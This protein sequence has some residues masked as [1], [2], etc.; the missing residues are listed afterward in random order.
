M[1]RRSTHCLAALLLL[2]LLTLR[3]SAQ[4]T[5][6]TIVSNGPSANRY[7]VAV[8]SE[9]YTSAQL[10]QFRIDA[11]N[12]INTLFTFDPYQEY[13]HYFNA[14]AIAV[15]SAQ[16]GSDHP[17]YPTSRTTYFNS[18]YDAYSDYLI[19]IPAG[20]QGQGKVD[21]LL[22]AFVPDCDLAILLVNDPV[23]GGSDGAA[24][25]AISSVS[26]ISGILVHETGHVVAGLG[27]EYTLANPGYPDTEEPNT[28]R[29]TNRA[30]IKWKAWISQDTPVP[31]PPVSQYDSVVGL[32]EGAH[33]HSNGWYRPKLN[34]I[35]QSPWTPEFCEVCREA[36]VLAFYR[37]VRPID[38]FS[39]GATL[40]S[41]TNP[42]PVTFSLNLL[43][44]ASHS[45]S[46]QWSTNGTALRDA[47]N[48]TFTCWP[49]NLSTGSNWVSAVTRDNTEMVRNDPTNLLAQTVTWRLNV[50]VPQLHLDSPLW[51]AGGKFAFRISG[52]APQGF[53][54]QA[55]TNL[56]T[57]TT[58]STNTLANGQFWFTNSA[59]GPSSKNFF[60]ARTPP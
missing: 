46:I 14:Y 45:L 21:A 37:E 38:L 7:N 56:L 1:D 52:N 26:G 49:T 20:S 53:A 48:Q 60:R 2:S 40:L 13:R 36:T 18:S 22:Q 4:G 28:T 44:P 32:F 50:N 10:D 39:P 35:M 47:T 24:K 59:G 8:L 33:Y 54:V 42:A 55:A 51:L 19:T 11:T 30:K 3:A 17:A 58:L 6:H 41:I 34:C 23:P 27:D 57:W 25:T 16:S 12:A 5:L 31:T 29:E 15:A 43:Q 9:G